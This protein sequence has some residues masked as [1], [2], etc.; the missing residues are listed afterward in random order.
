MV[1][2]S[3]IYDKDIKEQVFM[4]RGDERYARSTKTVISL[5]T[6]VDT[7]EGFV[8]SLLVNVFRDVGNG[9]LVVYDNDVVVYT[10]HLYI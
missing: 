1:R 8:Q 5:G 6:R 7:S 2:I 4:I 10:I 9:S 3:T